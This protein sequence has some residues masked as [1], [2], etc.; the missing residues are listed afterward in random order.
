MS[1]AARDDT[2]ANPLQCRTRAAHIRQLAFAISDAA[3]LER[4]NDMAL[5]FDRQADA[6]EREAAE[7]LDASSVPLTQPIDR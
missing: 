4:L 2:P 7:M 3:A 6:M 5:K 1:R